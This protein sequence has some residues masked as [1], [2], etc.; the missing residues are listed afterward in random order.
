MIH[1]TDIPR[2]WAVDDSVVHAIVVHD[3]LI[4]ASIATG[5]ICW[6][7]IQTHNMTKLMSR[8]SLALKWSAK[9]DPST[10]A[11]AIF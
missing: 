1:T 7:V 4:V 2:H 11:T 10:D 6:L 8:R 3:R 9:I 5:G